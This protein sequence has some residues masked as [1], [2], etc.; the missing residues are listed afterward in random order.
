MA[1]LVIHSLRIFIFFFFSKEKIFQIHAIYLLSLKR[2]FCFYRE[3]KL[4]LLQFRGSSPNVIFCE[5]KRVNL[6][7]SF[8][9]ESY[10]FPRKH[11]ENV[12]S[13]LQEIPLRVPDLIPDSASQ[14]RSVAREKRYTLRNYHN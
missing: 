12:L 3:E 2:Q 11:K 10:N 5:H 6:G 14:S 1:I 8:F 7:D 13:N 9:D 4:S